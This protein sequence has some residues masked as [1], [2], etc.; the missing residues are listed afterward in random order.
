M[1]GTAAVS[2]LTAQVTRSATCASFERIRT[3]LEAFRQTDR[4]AAS[5]ED[6]LAW[7]DEI[8]D[9]GRRVTA[10]TAVLVAE[11][12]EAGSAMRARHTRL[13]DWMARSGQETPREASSA[14]WAARALE[15]RPAVR[16]AAAGG[17]ITIGQAKA[18]G[19]ALDALP[20]SLD[21]ASRTAA[22]QLMLHEAQ[23]APAEKLRTM[24]DRILRQVAPEKSDSPEQR[25]AKLA[26]RDVRARSRRRLWF[27]PE[28]DGSIEFGGSLPVVAGRRLQ[29]M[30]QAV[31]DRRYRAAKDSRDR[32]AMQETPQQRAADALVEIL[33]AAAAGHSGDPQPPSIPVATAQLQVLIPY[34]D[35]LDRAAASGVLSDGTPL[36]AGELRVLACDADLIPA[37]LGSASEVLDLGRRV[38]L[39]PPSLRRAIGLRDGGCAFP[40]CTTP[41]RHCDLHHVRPWQ[42]GGRTEQGNL[43]A[44]CRVHHALC[45]PRPPTTGADGTSQVHDGWD[46]RIDRRGLP[47]FL[48][49]LAIDPGRTPVRRTGHAATLF[50]HD[51]PRRAG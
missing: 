43:V 10:L 36:S 9:L 11:A 51:Q 21:R 2:T 17:H 28:T 32:R 7:V 8:R 48:P 42:E 19:E 18:I 5:D 45:E 14:V 29:S 23:H 30:V 46:V 12:D 49:P 31:S 25:A 27:G 15:R 47:E 6:R 41:M 4:T 1:D 24:T 20:T 50:D 35:L 33:D 38:R 37:V 44:L 16:D 34:Q 40:G 26:E 13:E 39:A 22:E 3:L